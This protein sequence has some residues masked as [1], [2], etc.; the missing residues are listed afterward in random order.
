MSTSAFKTMSIIFIASSFMVLVGCT[1]SE[2]KAYNS[3][4]D[5]NERK[6]EIADD[7]E[8]CIKESTTEEEQSRCKAL[9]EGAKALQ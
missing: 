4:T 3:Q 9:L 6:M 1:S 5:L 8:K 2:E 7:Y